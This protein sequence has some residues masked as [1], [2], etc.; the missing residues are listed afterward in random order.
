MRNPLTVKTNIR[1][2]APRSKVWQALTDPELIKQY[3]FGTQAESDW[4]K[5]ST[6]TYSGEWQGK[7]Y[8]DKGKIIE[9]VPEKLLHTTYLSSAS[10]KEDSPENYANVIYGLAEEEGE[11]IVSLSQDNVENEEQQKHLHEN[12]N[13]VLQNLKQVLEK[14][15]SYNG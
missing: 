9:I 6:I 12:W 13:T 1:I 11:T 7:Q 8:Q 2:N 5:G 14:D 15:M 3:L 10:G 4:E